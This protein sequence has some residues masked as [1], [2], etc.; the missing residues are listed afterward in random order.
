VACLILLYFERRP[1]RITAPA[2]HRTSLAPV[3]KRV[4]SQTIA[5][6]TARVSVSVR[7]SASTRDAARA[8][9]PSPAASVVSSD[10][11]NGDDDGESTSGERPVT[12]GV[13]NDPPLQD[14]VARL[15]LAEGFSGPSVAVVATLDVPTAA[16]SPVP[17]LDAVRPTS[18]ARPGSASTRDRAVLPLG[19]ARLA[20][21]LP[22]LVPVPSGGARGKAPSLA[23]KTAAP[24]TQSRRPTPAAAAPRAPRPP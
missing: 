23:A 19:Q 4:I 6:V 16:V 8:L 1:P 7:V 22:S 3:L 18:A 2:A 20:P 5:G 17:N 13:G 10:I 14:S 24:R 9:A 12:I 15:T 21:N 11:D